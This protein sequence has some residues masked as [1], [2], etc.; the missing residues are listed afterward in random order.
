MGEL[1]PITNR[2]FDFAVRIVNLCK[3]LDERPGV[4]RTLTKQLIRSGT[5]VG[6]NV[7]GSLRR[8]K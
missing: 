8:L 2:T 6:A 4:S 7:G 1:V 3:V 5:S